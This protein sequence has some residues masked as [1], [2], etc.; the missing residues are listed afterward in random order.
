MMNLQVE[1]AFNAVLHSLHLLSDLI[2]RVIYQSGQ[3]YQPSFDVQPVLDRVT[4]ME[5]TG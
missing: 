3:N 4:V 5:D 2:K 1:T